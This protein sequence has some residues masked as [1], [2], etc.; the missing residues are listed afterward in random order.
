MYKANVVKRIRC[1]CLVI[2]FLDG[3]GGGF[4]HPDHP[5]ATPQDPTHIKH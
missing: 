4:D 1:F 5:L 2:F 3:I